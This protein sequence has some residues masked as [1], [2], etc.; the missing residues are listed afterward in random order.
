MTEQKTAKQPTPTPVDPELEEELEVEEGFSPVSYVDSTGHSTVGF[1]HNNVPH[2]GSDQFAY[3]TRPEART[4]LDGDVMETIRELDV[5]LPW[6][7]DL[8]EVRRRALVDMAFN[9]G[10]AKLCEFHRMLNCLRAG[11]WNG[12][13]ANGQLSVWFTQVGARAHRILKMFQ[14]GTDPGAA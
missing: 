5:A 14:T 4:V 12:A 9:L 8:D 6:A 2:D 11:D 13:A 7:R 3:L 10:V 1:G